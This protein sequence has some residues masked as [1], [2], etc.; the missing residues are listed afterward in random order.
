MLAI[1][2]DVREQLG[3]KRVRRALGRAVEALRVASELPA[4]RQ[5][6]EDLLVERKAAAAWV[7]GVRVALSG[8]PHGLLVH[9]AQTGGLPSRELGA[10]LSNSGTPD[11][12][13][14]KAKAEAERQIRD[15]LVDAGVDPAVIDG[16]IEADKKKGFR[17]TI[18]ARVI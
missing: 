1:E 4:W 14:R 15:A 7:F 11:V 3:A 10:R 8:L 6:D 12:T 5:W 18:A 2:L 16:L 9:L 17:L 13:A